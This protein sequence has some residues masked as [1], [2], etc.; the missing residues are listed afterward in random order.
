MVSRPR[1]LCLD[2]E[3]GHG[4]SSR[5]LFESI[6]YLDRK[7]VNLEVWCR[8]AGNIQQRYAEI[9]VKC[10]VARELPTFSSLP[11]LSRNLLTLGMAVGKFHRS[12]ALRGRLLREIDERFDLIHFNH[13]AL[14]PLA[15][16]LRGRA[17]VPLTMHIRT[18][19]HDS[20]F[21]R[22]QTRSIAAS[23]DHLIFITENELRNFAALGGQPNH[24]SVIHNIVTPS[25]KVAPHEMVARHARFK[26]GCLSNYSWTRGL[27]RLLDVADELSRSG[28]PEPLFVMAGDM[29]LTRSLPGDLGRIGRVGGTLADYVKKRALSDMFLFLGHVDEPER[30][31]AACDILIKPTREANPWGRDILEGLAAG[32]PV[33]SFGSSD[34]F[35]ENEVTGILR[36]EFDAAVTAADLVQV[37]DDENLRARLGAA[38]RARV[39]ELCNGSAR[40][41]DLYAVWRSTLGAG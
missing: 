19:L 26:V 21:A 5:S 4:G 2:I 14:F 33:I 9:G 29:R 12:R 1:V 10:C 38:G 31:L 18:N 28:R 20:A 30:V 40:A 25:D 27:D 7:A 24:S 22:W 34:T 39:N 17:N 37:M 11:R 35:V 13:E 15:R 36:E 16:W 6:R 32:K 3:G 23:I 41:A 8:K